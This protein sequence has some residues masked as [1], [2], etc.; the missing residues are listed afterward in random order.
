MNNTHF[1]DDYTE[2]VPNRSYSYDR[3]DKSGYTNSIL[4]YSNAGATSLFT[5]IDDLS[6]W[7]MNFYDHKVGDQKDIEQL[8]QKGKLNN[9][10]EI[11]YALGI[12]VDTYRG[13]K[14]YSHGGADAGYRTY[15]SVLPEL[16]MGFIVFSNNGNFDAGGKTTQIADLFVKDQSPKKTATQSG[17]KNLDDAILKDTLSVKKFSGDYIS[18]DGAHFTFKLKNKK[19]YWVVNNN[20]NLLIKTQKDTFAMFSR[21]EVK[22]VFSVDKTKNDIVDQ[23]WP[24]NH[25]LLAKFDTTAK[26]D[27]ILQTYTGTYYS[28]ELD[29]SYRIILK[30]HHLIL[31]NAKYDDAPLKLSGDDHLAND[32]W[33]MSHLHILRNSKN[34]ITGFEVNSGRIRHLLFKKTR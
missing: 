14:R 16:K 23:Y 15:I 6:K 27:K 4:S 8:T 13:Y 33:W 18:E 1:H 24:D 10:K 11:D 5:N 32:T 2:I 17:Y 20:T 3:N 26:P 28:S 25:R 31:T 34:Q 29:C 9:G 30:N 22:F 21:P 19:L 12:A 7:V